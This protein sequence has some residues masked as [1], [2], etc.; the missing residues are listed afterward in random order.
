MHT[1][2]AGRAYMWSFLGVMSH[3]MELKISFGAEHFFAFITLKWL[4]RTVPN[5]VFF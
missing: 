2:I 1:F 5:K 3:F 4:L